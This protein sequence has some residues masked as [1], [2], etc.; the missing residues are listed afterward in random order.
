MLGALPSGYQAE[1]FPLLRGQL[2]H[3]ITG[4][5]PLLEQLVE[6]RAKQS[7]QRPFPVVDVAPEPGPAVKTVGKS[8][9]RG[10]AGTS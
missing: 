2:G 5:L 7:Q 1:Q 8:T 3:G 9:R 4:A 6:V 10:R